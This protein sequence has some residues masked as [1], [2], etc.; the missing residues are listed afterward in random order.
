MSE[1]VKG[2]RRRRTK[3]RERGS[4]CH[5]SPIQRGGGAVKVLMSFLVPGFSSGASSFF[6]MSPLSPSL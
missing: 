6:P 5:T 3:E 1:K 2:S 4:I